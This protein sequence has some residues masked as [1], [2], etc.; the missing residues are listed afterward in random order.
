M[1]LISV[2]DILQKTMKVAEDTLPEVSTNM[3]NMLIDKAYELWKL[4]AENA[5]EKS[6]GSP[7]QWG[8]RYANTLKVSPSKGG[9]ASVYVD[10]G[11]PDVMFVNM[12][13]NGVR[14]WSISDALL[15][16]RAARTS[17]DGYTYVNVPFRKRTPTAGASEFTSSV[18]SSVIPTNVYEDLKAGLQTGK[19]AGEM[20][21][22]QRYEGD[23]GRVSGY[24]TFRVVSSKPGAKE[25]V[26]PG[27]QPTPVF[28]EVQREFENMVEKFVVKF[29]GSMAKGLEKDIQK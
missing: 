1:R 19:Q 5:P 26:H 21:G 16:S 3:A 27:K 29:V 22:L 28:E 4:K 23:Q 6:D 17:H 13:E 15:S 14:S 11:H 10:E 2:F 7:S 20:A 18:F 24:F 9:E 25:W 12:M 8:R